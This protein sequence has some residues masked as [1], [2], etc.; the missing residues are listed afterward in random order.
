MALTLLVFPRVYRYHCP[1]WHFRPGRDLSV[2]D[3]R[4]DTEV[5][6]DSV[7][8]VCVD[9]CAFFYEE[10]VSTEYTERIFLAAKVYVSVKY[11]C[12]GNN[13]ANSV[14]PAFNCFFI[15]IA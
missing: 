2:G 3:I 10:K 1:S 6:P 13:R 9:V 14:V 4:A 7:R 12:G 15:C 8:I 11:H 5:I